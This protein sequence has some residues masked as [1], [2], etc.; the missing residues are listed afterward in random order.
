MRRISSPSDGSFAATGRIV[1]SSAG[2]GK[3]GPASSASSIA[4]FYGGSGRRGLE[5]A[6]AV[7]D[8]RRPGD[9]LRSGEVDDRAG[10]VLGRADPAEERLR[11]AP[12]L[13]PG[14]T[15]TGPGA[16]P[17]TRTSGASARASTRVS[18]AWAALAAQWAAKD[19]H[20]W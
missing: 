14:S 4:S 1:A 20:G 10:D 15:A 13:L 7:D 18:I 19:G 17:H 11:G 3:R 6:A 5:E 12:L 8:E 2:A 9:E 16:I